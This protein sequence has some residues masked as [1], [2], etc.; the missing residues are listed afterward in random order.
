MGFRAQH[1]NPLRGTRGHIVL[2]SILA[3]KMLRPRKGRIEHKLS[4]SIYAYPRLFRSYKG[5]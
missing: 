1:K 3:Y 2:A 5:A 4:Q